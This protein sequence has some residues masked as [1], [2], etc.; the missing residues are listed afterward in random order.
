MSIINYLFFKNKRKKNKNFNFFV[1][2]FIKL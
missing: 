1:I 2:D